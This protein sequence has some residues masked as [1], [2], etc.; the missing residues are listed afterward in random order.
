VVGSPSGISG[1]LDKERLLARI[2]GEIGPGGVERARRNPHSRRRPRPCGLTVHPGFGCPNACLYCYVGDVLGTGPV[3]PRPT[4]LGGRELSYAL[5]LNPYF[6]PGRMGTFL[7][8]GAVCDPFHPALA[9]KTLDI[10][11]S[12]ASLLGNP[13]QF[14]TK[15]ALSP[16]LIGK[17][18]REAPVCPLITITTLEK[19]DKLEP[20]APS[21]WDRLETMRELRRAGFK[22][23]LFLRPLLPGLIEREADD[24]IS[25]ARY[26]GA[27]GVVVGALRAN[28]PILNRLKRVGLY[29]EVA[30][31]LG[32][33]EKHRINRGELVPVPSSDLK[34]LVLE[35]AREAGLTGFKAACCANA[36]V[37]GVPCT[38]L[39]WLRG[40][41]SRCPN[42]CAHKVPDVHEEDVRRALEAV[43]GLG[44]RAVRLGPFRLVVRVEG[45]P[46]RDVLSAA[47][48]ALEVA[49]RRPVVLRA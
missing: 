19:A 16:E 6:V 38:G 9:E 27:V 2:A 30:R 17:L 36:F 15:M 26:A 21:P 24:I 33:R 20:R 41:C 42:D 23:V 3:E 29:E 34:R 28:K 40:F 12:V 8:F 25:E 49:T 44:V 35:A 32:K 46:P 37:A 48:V 43:F 5:V 4:G 14:S 10:M 1:L 39:C 13:M 47:R 18:P 22:P 11:A 7:A 31:R 45:S